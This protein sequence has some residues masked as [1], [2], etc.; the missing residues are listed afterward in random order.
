MANSNGVTVTCGP[1][2]F[3]SDRFNGFTID[4]LRRDNTV[5]DIL[6]LS[7]SESVEVRTPGNDWESVRG[8]FEVENGDEVRFFRSSGTKG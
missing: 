3:T 6:N 4:E 8:T 5:S 2:T 1:N 7:G